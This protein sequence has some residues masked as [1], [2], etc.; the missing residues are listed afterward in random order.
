MFYPEEP[1]KKWLDFWTGGLISRDW[2]GSHEAATFA[3]KAR[4]KR[5]AKAI[6]PRAKVYRK[7]GFLKERFE[8]VK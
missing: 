3:N 7:R 8:E 2:S 5:K 4:A 6:H 1:E